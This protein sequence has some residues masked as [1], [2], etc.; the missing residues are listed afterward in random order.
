MTRSFER[1]YFQGRSALGQ[2]VRRTDSEPYIEIVGVVRDHMYGSY[3]DSTT[4]VFYTSYL[5][6]PRVSTQIRPVVIHVRTSAPPVSLLPT[7]RDAITSVDATVLAD[8]RT[9][10]EATGTE[11]T[12]RRIGT[13]LLSLIGT[14]GLLLATIGL[15]GL[16]GY[17]VTT[18]TPEIGVRMGIALAPGGCSPKAAPP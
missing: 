10:R 13:Q 5:Q 4:P 7:V 11:A 15:Y 8:V 6:Q 14:L 12:Q 3:G 1:A 17:V 16:M 2:R 9:L 18:R